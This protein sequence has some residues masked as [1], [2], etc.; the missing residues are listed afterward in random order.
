[1]VVLSVK[2]NFKMLQ[3]NMRY[4]VFKTEH[5]FLLKIDLFCQVKNLCFAEGK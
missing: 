2:Y 3:N 5:L 4:F 1:M